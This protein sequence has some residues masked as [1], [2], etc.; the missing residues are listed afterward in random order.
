MTDFA[1]SQ[2]LA[3]WRRWTDI[4]LLILAIGSL[5]LLLL[6]VVSHRLSPTDQSF[7]LGVNIAVF[8]AFSIDY[9]CELWLTEHKALYVRSQWSSLVIVLAQLVAL[10]PSF[11]IFG[12][13]RAARALRVFSTLARVVGIGSASRNEGKRFFRE[14]AASLAFGI[15]GF[16]L[17]TSA[18]AFTIA[19][20][21]GE[22][23][24]V[25]SFFDALWWSAA[26]ITTVGYGD[27]YPITAAGR[28]IAVFTMI[29]GI[30]TLAV[31]TARIA[32]FLIKTDSGV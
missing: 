5:P 7:L 29:V 3:A 23:R 22:G 11:G 1:V 31:V 21:V 4:P 8:V 18:V 30:S 17:V 28:V 13:L 12:I 25:G 26:T 9:L 2:G 16:T 24:R 14:K 15:A 27:I 20:D 32:Q 19:E 10:L 6:E